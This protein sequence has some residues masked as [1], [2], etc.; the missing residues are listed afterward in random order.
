MKISAKAFYRQA[1]TLGPAEDGTA[2]NMTA[3]IFLASDGVSSPYSP[4]HPRELRNGMTDGQIVT[5]IICDYISQVPSPR[6]IKNVLLDC[7]AIV[8]LEH[9]LAEKDPI[10]EA[11]GGACVA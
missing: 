8:L 7:N 1:S 6:N 11:V 4:S 3:Q 10:Q 9:L 2:L 5:K